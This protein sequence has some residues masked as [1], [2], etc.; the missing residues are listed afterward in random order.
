MPES[1]TKSNQDRPLRIFLSS[2]ARDLETHRRAVAETIDHYGQL[3]LKMESFGARP[4]SSLEVCRELAAEA[5]ALVVVVAHRYGWVPT[6]DEGGDGERSITWHEV[7][8]AVEAGKP[9]FV[10]LVDPEHPWTHT[11]EQ[12]RLTEPGADPAAVAHA[13][14]KLGELKEFLSARVRETFRGPDDLAKKVSRDLGNWL[15]RRRQGGSGPPAAIDLDRDQ[16][17][18]EHFAEQA[19]VRFSVTNLS[20]AQQKV[21]LHLVVEEVTPS[22]VVRLRKAGAILKEFDL[23]AE[24]GGP[25]EID[26]L[27]GKPVQIVLAAGE[28]EAFRLVLRGQEG[29][30]YR[31]A[32]AAT[33]RELE[34]QQ[35]SRVSSAEFVIEFPIR[36][37]VL[38]RQ[39]RQAG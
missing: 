3:S 11:K 33:L 38:L 30:V 37:A 6:P 19:A 35:E 21:G 17:A 14:Q 36:S 5:D 7:E 8:A 16:I 22:E 23:E 9:V 27:A 1:A 26:L 39:R 4:G 2:T 18:A 29:M 31:C 15:V 12:D 32:L 10:Y 34:R 24:L 25:G 28:S 20:R 13:V